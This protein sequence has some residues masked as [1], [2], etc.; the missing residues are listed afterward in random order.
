MN[1]KHIVT[2]IG[3]VLLTTGIIG[4]I[5]SGI[6]AMPTVIGNIQEAEEN[7][8]KEEVLYKNELNLTKL[9]IESS[10]SGIVIKKYNGKDIVVE[11]NGNKELSNIRIEEH[12][13][14]LTIK[15]E[16][17][18]NK[19]ST[20]SIDDMVRYFVNELYSQHYS[21]IIVYVPENI[22]INIK[23]NNGRFYVSED[24][25][26][27]NVNFDT[28]YGSILLDSNE[29]IKNLNIKSDSDIAIQVREIYS[30]EN[31]NIEANAIS[32]N[33]NNYIVKEDKIPENVKLS[34]FNDYNSIYINT[35][36]PIAKNLNIDSKSTVELDLPLLDYKFNF[37]IKTSRGIDFSDYNYERYM[38]SEL[39]KYFK[40]DENE[41]NN[42]DEEV[43][44]QKELIGLMNEQLKDNPITYNINIKS[45]IVRFN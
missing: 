40:H 35:K 8:N 6:D 34:I 7:Y 15:E 20:N 11:R 43:Y 32:I 16:Y 18:N 30:T 39:E 22:D 29:K 27:N 14:E 5:W 37:D 4:G 41:E 38:G 3:V 23:T 28:Q 19:I 25:K 13:K 36:S 44:N 17:R 2:S 33:E 42:G 10:I 21:D 31:L 24:I 12:N 1:K 45:S 26:L 9:N